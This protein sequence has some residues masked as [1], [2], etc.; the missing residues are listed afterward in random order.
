MFDGLLLFALHFPASPV[1]RQILV[2][3]NYFIDCFVV[4]PKRL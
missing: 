1:V 4:L 2:L 3:N